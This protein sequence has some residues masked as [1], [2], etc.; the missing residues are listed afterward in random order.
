MLDTKNVIGIGYIRVS[1]RKQ[2]DE[3]VS[4]EVQTRE[5]DKKLRDLGCTNILI[6]EDEGKS[7]KSIKGRDGFQEA[8]DEAIKSKAKYFCTYDTSRLARN[9]ADAVETVQTLRNHNIKLVCVTAN[10]DDTPEGKLIF[11]VLSSIDQFYSDSLGAKI[12]V[13]NAKLRAQGIFPSKAPKGYDNIRTQGKADIVLNADGKALKKTFHRYI[14]GHIDS[15]REV[16]ADLDKNGFE[17][18][19]KTSFQTAS[20]LLKTPFYA[21]MFY[22]RSID[23][24]RDHVYEPI[25]TKDEFEFIQSKLDGRSVHKNVYQKIHPDYPLRS[26]MYCAKCGRKMKGYPAKGN[27]G[28]YYYY[29]CPT[30]GCSRARRTVELH[31]EF[32]EEIESWSP[33]E[34]LLRLFEEILRRSLSVGLSDVSDKEKLLQKR[35]RELE[36]ELE[37]IMETIPKLKLPNLISSYESKYLEIQKQI[38]QKKK[39][40]GHSSSNWSK[41]NS[42]PI[43]EE[44]VELLKNPYTAWKKAGPKLRHQYQMW[45]FPDGIEYHPDSGLRTRRK[46]YTYQLLEALEAGDSDM[47]ET[48]GI[49][50][51]SSKHC[52]VSFY[53]CCK[54]CLHSTPKSHA[55]KY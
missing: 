27:G 39:E 13:S 46:N 10:F 24:F 16:A 41:E 34:G 38:E 55:K 48:A 36:K 5:V 14:D 43:I 15:L 42:E 23:D 3:G 17:P 25:I 33:D 37:G 54:A 31:D 50:P 45:I 1:T 35:I 51:A 7:A 40:F 30:K 53:K 52:K 26:M 20:R 47:V 8:R 18:H 21:G 44:G 19:K 32:G 29:D 22:D 4:L 49:E 11:T 6:F 2:A 12:K 9:T 28:T